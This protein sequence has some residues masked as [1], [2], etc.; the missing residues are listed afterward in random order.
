MHLPN[1]KVPTRYLTALTRLVFTHK[2]SQ[3]SA[4]QSTFTIYTNPPSDFQMVPQLIQT[5]SGQQQLVYTPPPPSSAPHQIFGGAAPQLANIIGPNGQ[6]H[7][8]QLVGGGGI[9]MG[10]AG[11][12]GIV[13]GSSAAGGGIV[14]SSSSAGGMGSSA[15]GGGVISL[16]MTPG[17]LG[18][19]AVM[20]QPPP[21][22][23]QTTA[24]LTNIV[25]SNSS[26]TTTDSTTS[27]AMQQQNNNGYS[28]AATVP[29]SLQVGISHSSFFSCLPIFYMVPVDT[30]RTVP[31]PG[32]R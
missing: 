21:T 11:G 22:P 16:Q 18:G 30:Y 4:R 1:G 20:Q 26:T 7:Q 3:N 28:M 25:G 6:I 2:N 8:V 17:M 19:I 24:P 32:T 10:S 15:P 12:G 29:V 5:A 27:S 9:V 14:M 13:M 23:L 31:V